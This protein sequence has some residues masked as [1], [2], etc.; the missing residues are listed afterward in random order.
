LGLKV[1][2]F[3]RKMPEQVFSERALC[4]RAAAVLRQAWLIH[5]VRD[6]T[7]RDALRANCKVVVDAEGKVDEAALA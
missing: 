5:T 2:A 1:E 6:G 4:D 7:A 3:V